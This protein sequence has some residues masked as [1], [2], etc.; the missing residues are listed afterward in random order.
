MVVIEDPD[1]VNLVVRTPFQNILIV[2][3]TGVFASVKLVL[4]LFMLPDG[5]SLVIKL[6]AVK[7]ALNDGVPVN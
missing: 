3:V 5:V 2:P 1:A 6:D 7:Y 4:L